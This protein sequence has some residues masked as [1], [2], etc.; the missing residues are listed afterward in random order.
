[1]EWRARS[2]T[3]RILLLE[4]HETGNRD[5]FE[6]EENFLRP[7]FPRNLGR[8]NTILLFSFPRAVPMS[9]FRD[10]N[11]FPEF[12]EL[13]QGEVTMIIEF[14]RKRNRSIDL[15][16]HFFPA[17]IL[18]RFETILIKIGATNVKG[19]FFN[20]ARI[21]RRIQRTN[22]TVASLLLLLSLRRSISFRF[23][24]QIQPRGV[25]FYSIFFSSFL[26]N[27]VF[28]KRR[29]E[30]LETIVGHCWYLDRFLNPFER[31]RGETG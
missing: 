21:I 14:E 30:W 11:S 26:F 18:Y 31:R 24:A 29:E 27:I 19:L 5:R 9:T 22:S 16:H 1:M 6:G 20:S 3:R 10:S 15:V 2:S 7:N 13:F 4:F 28:T 8:K 12:S 23:N 17:R 25:L